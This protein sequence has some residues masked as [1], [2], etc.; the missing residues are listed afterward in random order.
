MAVWGGQRLATKKLINKTLGKDGFFISLSASLEM[1]CIYT[2]I[3]IARKLHWG[4]FFLFIFILFFVFVL[5]WVNKGDKWDAHCPSGE[6]LREKATF[7]ILIRI[8]KVSSILYKWIDNFII[9]LINIYA[10]QNFC[11]FIY[12]F[13][14]LS[15]WKIITSDMRVP[16]WDSNS[17]CEDVLGVVCIIW[18]CG[19]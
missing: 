9:L 14:S 10:T 12:F 16:Q 2:Y 15:H 1:Y 5:F 17:R 11:L 4:I 13:S 19:C 3:Y 8:Y 7:K 18:L 6:A